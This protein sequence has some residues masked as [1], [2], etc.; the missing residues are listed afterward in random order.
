M[1]KKDKILAFLSRYKFFYHL[2]AKFSGFPGIYSRTCT[3]AQEKRQTLGNRE[4]R[5]CCYFNVKQREIYKQTRLQPTE[6]DQDMS[7]RTV[8]CS[9]P[10]AHSQQ[11][12]PNASE[13]TGI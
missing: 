6:S 12:S 8:I 9:T 11:H 5:C 3:K 13:E 1:Q 10:S 2:I 7:I 4:V